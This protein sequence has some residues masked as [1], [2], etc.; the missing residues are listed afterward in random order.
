LQE[1]GAFI[2]KNLVDKEFVVLCSKG[3]AIPVQTSS[4]PIGFQE[5][6]ALPDFKTVCTPWPLL[7]PRKYSWCSFLLEA[8]STP[9][10]Q[11]SQKRFVSMKNFSDHQESNL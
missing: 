3:K 5:V 10:P 11:C 9:G 1:S 8:E 4:M 2:F 6:E 7:P